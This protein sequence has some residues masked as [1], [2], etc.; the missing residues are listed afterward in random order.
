MRIALLLLPVTITGQLFGGL[1]GNIMRS[2]ICTLSPA[3]DECQEEQNDSQLETARI[4][5]PDPASQCVKVAPQFEQYYDRDST[6]SLQAVDQITLSGY[7]YREELIALAGSQP[8]C[9]IKG[10]AGFTREDGSTFQALVYGWRIKETPSRF[11]LV[12]VDPGHGDYL[13]SFDYLPSIAAW[14]EMSSLSF[15]PMEEDLIKLL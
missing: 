11:F 15:P 4:F 6:I 1:P 9:R 7:L 3:A 10:A 2:L 14:N 8:T 13:A 5:E 12:F